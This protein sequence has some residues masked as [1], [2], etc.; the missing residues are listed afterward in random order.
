M[1]LHAPYAD[2]R[3]GDDIMSAAIFARARYAVLLCAA[4]MI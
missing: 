4:P 2:A 3:Y 1:P